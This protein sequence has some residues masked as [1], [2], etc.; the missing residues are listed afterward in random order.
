MLVSTKVGNNFYEEKS[1]P[2]LNVSS[3]LL[4]ITAKVFSMN[5]T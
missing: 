3:M 2:K 5:I 1:I 4:A